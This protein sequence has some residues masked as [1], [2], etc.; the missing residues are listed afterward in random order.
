MKKTEKDVKEAINHIKE[1]SN[2]CA[3]IA[4]MLDDMQYEIEW[5]VYSS[6]DVMNVL[7]VFSHV[8]GN[9]TLWSMFEQ[10]CSDEFIKK[11]HIEFANELHEL[12][13]EHVKIDTR[14][15]YKW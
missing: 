3:D 2:T 5:K 6:Q 4:L 7:H 15:Y 11:N 12:M 13:R 8:A 9:Y 10:G 1:R 14:S